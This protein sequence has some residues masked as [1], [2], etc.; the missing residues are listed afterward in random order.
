MWP[1]A[2]PSSQ[3][4]GLGERATFSQL[5]FTDVRDTTPDPGVPVVTKTSNSCPPRA[6]YTREECKESA[7]RYL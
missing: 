1:A 3:V 5:I 6:V 4:G 7:F 2:G